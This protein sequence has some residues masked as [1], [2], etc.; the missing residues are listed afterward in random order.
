MDRL[1]DQTK[2]LERIVAALKLNAVSFE[3]SD[4][5]DAPERVGKK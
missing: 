5:L 3:G 1:T 4:S 2:T